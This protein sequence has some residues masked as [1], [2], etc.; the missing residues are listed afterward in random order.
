MMWRLP[1]PANDEGRSWPEWAVSSVFFSPH[2][3]VAVGRPVE[4]QDGR[5]AFIPG[6]IR[7]FIVWLR[8]VL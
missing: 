1:R 3:G 4:R 5:I 2:A 8:A 7:P 6:P